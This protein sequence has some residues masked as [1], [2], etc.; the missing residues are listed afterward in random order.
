V[1]CL[2]LS[3]KGDAEVR[4]F[5]SG[6]RGYLLRRKLYGV[7]GSLALQPCSLSTFQPR[8]QE[9]GGHASSGTYVVQRKTCM[10]LITMLRFVF[11][12]FRQLVARG[13][14]SLTRLKLISGNHKDGK[15]GQPRSRLNKSLQLGPPADL[16][17]RPRIL[18]C[19]ASGLA[20]HIILFLFHVA[21]G[22]C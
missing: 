16:I 3:Q 14:T 2:G 8:F 11:K 4:N 15:R 19:W 10:H 13:C 7:S 21:S 1:L 6:D 22:R 9:D 20:R 5:S 18:S 17:G 12:Q